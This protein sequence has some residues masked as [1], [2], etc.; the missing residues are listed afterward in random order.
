MRFA[1]CQAEIVE[2]FCEAL[3]TFIGQRLGLRTEF[4][5]DIPWQEREQLL[6]SGEIDVG[7]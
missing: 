3:T 6:D 4:I 1:T 5:C 7:P 2:P